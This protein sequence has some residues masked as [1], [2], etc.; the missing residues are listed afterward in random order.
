MTSQELSPELERRIASLEDEDNQG[1]S[2]TGIDW[3]WLVLLGI[4]GPALLLIWGW[5]S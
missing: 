4:V 5:L 3:L 2:F 1:T